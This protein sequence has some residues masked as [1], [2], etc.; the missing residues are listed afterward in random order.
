MKLFHLHKY[1]KP[2]ASQ[3][4][5]FH[6]LNIIYECKCGLRKLITE[7]RRFDKPFPIETNTN[8]TNKEVKGLLSGKIKSI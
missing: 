5:S 7:T 6:T 4:V 2:I 8:L 3:Y 1:K